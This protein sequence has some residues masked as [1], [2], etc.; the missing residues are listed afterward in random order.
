M[1]T[2]L[3]VVAGLVELFALRRTQI[4][5]GWTAAIDGVAEPIYLVT[6]AKTMRHL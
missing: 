4:P 6:A 5:P 3:A 2:V 1:A